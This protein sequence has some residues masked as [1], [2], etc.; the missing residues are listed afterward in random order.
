M[1]KNKSIH[2][3]ASGGVAPPIQ[4]AGKQF[5]EKH[6]TKVDFTIGKAEK[7]ISEIREKKI[8]DILSCGAEY[9]LD[10]AEQLGII[11]KESR[12]SVGNRRSVILVQEGN[13]KGIQSL[14]D[15][16]KDGTRVGIS[17]SGCLVGL[18]DDVC[19]KA[20][21]TNQIRKNI[22][23]FADG[24]G[25][26][27]ALINQKKVDAIFGW[28]AFKNI[29]PGT[30]DIVEVPKEIQVF[31]STGVALISYC[32]EV[33]LASKFVEYLTSKEVKRIYAEYGW[34]YSM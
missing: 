7:L 9:I 25:A 1:P 4:K 19:S 22:T 15:L 2:V 14:K 5:Q 30:S 10:E 31:R 34:V 3:F 13:P 29:W 11:R 23:D 33:E 24:C 12:R 17:T 20:G 16:A 6:G 21:L 26:L 28:N 8:G 27:M 32:K 18:W